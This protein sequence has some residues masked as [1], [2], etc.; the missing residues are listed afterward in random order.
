MV[1][2]LLGARL[3]D[4]RVWMCFLSVQAQCLVYKMSKPVSSRMAPA[5][6]EYTPEVI[7]A[8]A[9]HIAQFSL[10][11]IRSIAGQGQTGIWMGR[12]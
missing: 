1:A 5:G 4:D 3:D 6:F 8:L 2:E 10:A 9:D 11:G 7:D 12:G